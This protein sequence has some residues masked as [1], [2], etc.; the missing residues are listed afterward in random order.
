VAAF[1]PRLWLGI[2]LLIV[3]G[4]VIGISRFNAFKPAFFD[5]AFL[6]LNIAVPATL[7]LLLLLLAGPLASAEG[8]TTRWRYRLNAGD[9]LAGESLPAWKSPPTLLLYVVSCTPLMVFTPDLE[10]ISQ[11]LD[12]SEELNPLALFNREVWIRTWLFTGAAFMCGAAL[13]WAL[14][15]IGSRLGGGRLLML[16]VMILW[17][18]PMLLAGAWAFRQ[19]AHLGRLLNPIATFSPPGAIWTAWSGSRPDEL[20][21]QMIH[22]M[23]GP[24]PWLWP[25]V[26]FQAVVALAACAAALRV[27]DRFAQPATRE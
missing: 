18:G 27:R 23:A 12:A 20:N 7:T 10:G 8:E 2:V 15:R 6:V 11:Y 1:S 13:I 17:L 21:V 16:V 26:A 4:S 5:Q 14:V 25:G 22:A 9:P 24:Y 3:V 19:D